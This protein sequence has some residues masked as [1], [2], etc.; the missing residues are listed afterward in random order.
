MF[1]WC[2]LHGHD[3]Q[4]HKLKAGTAAQAHQPKQDQTQPKEQHNFNPQPKLQ[5]NQ[6]VSQKGIVQS[7]GP[8]SP[9]D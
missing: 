9:Y 8:A 4:A 5:A 3:A 2:Y 1:V 6:S 7:S